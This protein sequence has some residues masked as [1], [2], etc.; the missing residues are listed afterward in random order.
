MLR[1]DIEK[2][3]SLYQAGNKKVKRTQQV[4]Q[5]FENESVGVLSG[6]YW[7]LSDQDL[8]RLIDSASKAVGSDARLGFDF[9]QTRASIAQTASNEKLSSENVFASSVLLA[10]ATD[11]VLPV[12][13]IYPLHTP[14]NTFFGCDISQIDFGSDNRFILVENGEVMKCWAG[15]LLPPNWCD[16]TLIYRGHGSN[17]VNVSRA[18]NQVTSSN[19]AGFFDFDLAGIFMVNDSGCG[20]ILVPSNLEALV[21]PDF[22]TKYNKTDTFH[23][24]N[25]VYANR[26]NTLKSGLRKLAIFISQHKLAITQEH[27]VTHKIQLCAVPV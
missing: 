18:L 25:S 6:G 15:A 7:I 9:T 5:L 23:S 17:L 13:S 2:I 26:I 8:N 11:H 1:K 24:Q 22:Y 12:Q 10:R 3:I 16:A 20:Y 19:M 14:H 27:L 4:D 21:F